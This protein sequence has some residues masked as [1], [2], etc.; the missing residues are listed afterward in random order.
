M[1]G[2]REGKSTETEGKKKVEG[3][4]QL[5]RVT[6][7]VRMRSRTGNKKGRESEEEMK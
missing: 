2:G 5:K 7:R 6:E 4:W 1:L 3:G